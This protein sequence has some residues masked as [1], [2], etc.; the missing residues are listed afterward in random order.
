MVNS[1]V[2][3]IMMIYIHGSITNKQ[4]NNNNS[5]HYHLTSP[6]ALIVTCTSSA[7][8]NW[9]S[10]KLVQVSTL[11]IDLGYLLFSPGDVAPAEEDAYV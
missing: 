3:S 8:A 10:R 6:R 4:S 1:S 2:T 5:K 9:I 11:E 7:T